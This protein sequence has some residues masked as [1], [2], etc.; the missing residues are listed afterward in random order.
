M[1]EGRAEVRRAL[2]LL[3]R[4]NLFGSLPRS[5]RTADS[6]ASPPRS[7]IPPGTPD[8]PVPATSSRRARNLVLQ[9]ATG[10]AAIPSDAP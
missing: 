8:A 5:T 6:S 10:C 1:A 7:A 3:A 4:F 9:T 2:S